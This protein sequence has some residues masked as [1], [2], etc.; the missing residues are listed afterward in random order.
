MAEASHLKYRRDIDGLRAF[1]VLAVVL[2]HA[3]PKSFPGGF[4]GVDVFFVISGYLISGIIFRELEKGL[5][6]LAGFY[7]RRV[8]RIF[9]ALL[10]V[11]FS[12]LAFG[13]WALFPLEYAQL[14]K[15][16][17]AGMAFV[18]N[19]VLWQESGYFDTAAEGKPL[20]HLWSLGIEEQFYIIWPLFV[21]F[22]WR[23]RQRFL[24]FCFFALV[25]FLSCLSSSFHTE[26][27]A[28]FSPVPRMWE[29]LIGALL[30]YSQ[31][32]F[33][34]S[35]LKITKQKYLAD[36]LSVAGLVLLLVSLLVISKERA[37]PGFW[38][39]MP[40]L[41]TGLLILVGETA[42]VNKMLLT[43]K[44]AVAI[45]LISYPLYLWHWPLLSYGHILGH[46]N[47]EARWILVVLSFLLATGTYFWIEKPLRQGG[48]IRFKIASMLALSLILGLAGWGIKIGDG[49]PSRPQVPSNAEGPHFVESG[50]E[51]PESFQKKYGL[52]MCTRPSNGRSADVVVFGDSHSWR[53][54]AALA[55]IDHDHQYLMLGKTGGGNLLKPINVDEEILRPEIETVI[56]TYE[57]AG[58]DL[59][60]EVKIKPWV[61][62]GKNVILI[63]DN[64]RLPKLPQDCDPRRFGPTRNS[65]DCITL[66]SEQIRRQAWGRQKFFEMNAKY[67][68]RVRVIDSLEVLCDETH[69]PHFENGIYLYDDEAHLSRTG[70]EKVGRKIIETLNLLRSR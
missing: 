19:L 57:Q 10:F 70:A 43:K 69:C 66:K 46:R 61:N 4:V 33:P 14:G 64:P 29:L 55:N 37:F 39:L 56:F 54:F 11:I 25:S 27:E 58:S 31:L 60:P 45:G 15:H 12:C 49:I 21:W 18:S 62:A 3:F 68:E 32:Y 35:V 30:A 47:D 50:Q 63:V 20:L 51:C 42:S 52:D 23:S 44:I 53:Y 7:S 22:L 5:F 9:P 24:F 38:A 40:T 36:A 67:P 48:M 41:G 26:V 34:Q 6:S 13:W 16:V 59:D 28:F 1:A 8:R 2:F 65:E 17:A